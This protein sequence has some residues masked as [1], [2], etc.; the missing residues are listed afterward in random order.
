MMR[1]K[2][3]KRG[4]SM[5]KT[6]FFASNLKKFPHFLRRSRRQMGDMVQAMG[7]DEAQCG[8][9]R[10]QAQSNRREGWQKREKLRKG[11]VQSILKTRDVAAGFHLRPPHG[12]RAR[13]RDE[14]AQTA[15]KN[16]GSISAFAVSE[17]ERKREG[18]H[19]RSK[20]RHTTGRKTKKKKTPNLGVFSGRGDWI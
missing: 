16:G 13:K 7:R 10:A 3:E 5:L 2:A 11:R 17:S 1:Q 4:R 12:G 14:V 15:H 6:P 9:R 19:K 8:R 18:L 20:R